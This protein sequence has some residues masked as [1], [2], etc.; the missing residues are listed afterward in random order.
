MTA[1]ALLFTLAAIGISETA[2]LIRVRKKEQ[3]PVCPIGEDCHSV[4]ES[5]YRKL[6]LV[7]NDILGFFFYLLAAII[8]SFL[9]IGVQPTSLW[10]IILKVMVSAA[11]IFSVFLSYLQ[12]K[13]I[14]VWCSWCL[15]SAFTIWLMGIILL[16]T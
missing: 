8:T 3:R 11:S 7:P 12:W 15:L 13:V 5:N 9:V 14:K 6:F 4:L 2:Y 16:L 10:L 1:Q